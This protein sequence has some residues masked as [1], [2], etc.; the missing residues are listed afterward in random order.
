MSRGRLGLPARPLSVLVYLL[1]LSLVSLSLGG[2]FG[3]FSF[4]VIFAFLIFASSMLGA[5]FELVISQGSAFLIFVMA[6]ICSCYLRG[7]LE[8]D[9]SLFS[10]CSLSLIWGAVV[11]VGYQGG[12]R[13]FNELLI[14]NGL[15]FYIILNV[16]LWIVG[17]RASGN[18]Y[19]SGGSA[20]VLG[21]LGVDTDRVLFPIAAGYN[22]FGV[23]AGLAGVCAF[24]D[25][26]QKRSFTSILAF[27]FC[28]LALLLSDSRGAVFGFVF[29]LALILI[30]K[31]RFFS[32]RSICKFFI[33]LYPFVTLII[34]SFSWLVGV[35]LA[36]ASRGDDALSGR[37]LIWASVIDGVM[38]RSLSE[39]MFGYGYLGHK[40]S[41][42]SNGYESLFA[43]LDGLDPSVVNVHSSALQNFL[44]LGLIGL[45]VVW[46]MLW[47][48]MIS[49]ESKRWGRAE[50]VYLFIIYGVVVGAVDLTF[51]QNN[52]VI[53]LIFLYL[54]ANV[55]GAL[56]LRAITSIPA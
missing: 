29:C 31:A 19:E 21:I 26:F 1:P 17:V 40:V 47:H 32:V 20:K 23:L 15:K 14:F 46:G 4:L 34:Q 41:G 43:H 3:Y 37:G 33:I 11:V 6:I 51:N 38:D 55:A 45:I 54:F 48:L 16:V 9:I 10:A 49:G 36:G 25:L 18:Y 35:L 42:I 50:K 22:G 8:E 5:S 2:A 12:K 13:D 52:L 30:E 28:L 39:L 53:F 56:R 7:V 44:D 27:G 24:V